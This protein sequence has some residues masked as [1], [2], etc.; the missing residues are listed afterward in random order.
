MSAFF[1]SKLLVV[2]TACI[3]LL[4][5][6][7]LIFFHRSTYEK[8]IPLYTVGQPT[9]GNPE[10]KVQVVIFEDPRCNNCIIFHQENYKK[11]YDN[12][13]SKDLIRYTVYLLGEMPNSTVTASMLLCINNQSTSAFF[14]FL[15]RY[16]TN[17][18]LALTAEELNS[19]LLWL[20]ENSSLNINSKNL[21]NCISLKTF[22]N[23]VL[24]NTNYARAI[25]GGVI[26]TPTIFVNGI[27]LVR[28]TY[29]QLEKLIQIELKKR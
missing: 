22:E 15:G 6:S 16:Y 9:L 3:F 11:L 7:F 1:Q 17:P 28:P 29:G 21:Q 4:T 23:Q 24:E 14:E 26:K 25:M 8:P 18:P 2:L 13:I 19:E 12:F 10:A 20:V 27:R 5:F